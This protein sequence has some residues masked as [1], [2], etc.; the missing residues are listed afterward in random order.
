MIRP[1]SV[2]VTR[3]GRRAADLISD[4]TG[5]A[6]IDAAPETITDA[7][8]GLGDVDVIVSAGALDV[9]ALDR[10]HVAADRAGTRLGFV[11][12]WAGPEVASRHAERLVAPLAPSDLD[13][14][15]VVAANVQPV[16]SAPLLRVLP[17]GDAEL[18]SALD[19]HRPYVALTT[20]SNGID[21]RLGEAVLCGLAGMS[22]DGPQSDRFLP[23]AVSTDLC[24]R[25]SREQQTVRPPAFVPPEALRAQV[26]V[27]DVCNGL[28]T[29]TATFDQA[30]SIAPRLVTSD[31]VG[32]VLTTYKLVRDTRQFGEFALALFAA[33][34]T[35]GEVLRALRTVTPLGSLAVSPY[36]LLGDPRR[37][38][39]LA[40]GRP[41]TEATAG[42]SVQIDPALPVVA[43]RASEPLVVADTGSPCVLAPMAGSDYEVLVCACGA[44]DHRLDAADSTA[45]L[46]RLAALR[47]TVDGLAFL[48]AMLVHVAANPLVTGR[49]DVPAPEPV[50][51]LIR[52]L[53]QIDVCDVRSAVRGSAFIGAAV[54]QHEGARLVALLDAH[55]DFL[56]RYVGAVGSANT[57]YL[58]PLAYERVDDA[59]GTR[60]PGCGEA[61]LTTVMAPVTTP[62]VRAT[63]MCPQCH[64]VCDRPSALPTLLVDAAH[65]EPGTS[66]RLVVRPVEP[67]PTG[68]GLLVVAG[69]TFE[70][71]PW[72]S[73]GQAC[74]AL[75]R[76]WHPAD[77]KLTELTLDLPVPADCPIGL[78]FVTSVLFLGGDLVIA[79]GQL[80]VA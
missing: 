6:Q 22:T 71:V 34:W 33:G 80:V 65:A 18:V 42:T 63:E 72:F 37:R 75:R 16:V 78:H 60:C 35:A 46:S 44:T 67:L 53:S 41:V 13:E 68:P 39:T 38:L 62:Q 23:C 21:A 8:A 24:K 69:V 28:L 9:A 11:Y 10:I 7:L 3:D 51:D 66:V 61:L 76:E 27:Y 64:L 47:E 17:L 20:H 50:D 43:I 30:G 56:L 59:E 57:Q 74:S 52:T 55:A 48:R 54:A 70:A 14:A 29:S 45:A 26:L 25:G 77:A 49:L 40:G 36:L 4:A 5:A 19:A 32:C 2:V 73:P 12:G 58:V 15:L 79:R 31:A 1:V